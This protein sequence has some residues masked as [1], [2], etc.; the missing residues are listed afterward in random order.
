MMRE[1]QSKRSMQSTR[2]DEDYDDCIRAS[3]VGISSQNCSPNLANLTHA[4]LISLFVDVSSVETA[5]SLEQLKCGTTF[6][7]LS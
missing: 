7:S 3:N 6:V 4:S 5:S 1:R 2:L